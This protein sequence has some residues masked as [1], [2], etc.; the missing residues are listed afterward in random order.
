MPRLFCVRNILLDELER[1]KLGDL[2]LARNFNSIS[3]LGGTF[4]YMSPEVVNEETSVDYRTDIWSFG[5]V[6]YEMIT[7]EKLFKGSVGFK[8]MNDIINMKIQLPSHLNPDFEDIL[9]K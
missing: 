9:K 5:C 1:V 7:L 4:Q 8:I 2:G 3:R 6:L